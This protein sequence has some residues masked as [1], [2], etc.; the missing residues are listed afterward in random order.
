MK[1]KKTDWLRNLLA[2][3]R[4]RWLYSRVGVKIYAS[5]KNCK[6]SAC[7]MVYRDGILIFSMRHAKYLYFLEKKNNDVIYF[8]T[9]EERIKFEQ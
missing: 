9:I 1:L 7:R 4:K 6:C 2:N 8:D 5:K 3:K